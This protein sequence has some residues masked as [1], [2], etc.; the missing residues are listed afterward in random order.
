[1]QN[2]AG[3]RFALFLASRSL[4]VLI[5]E[6]MILLVKN[7]DEIVNLTLLSEMKFKLMLGETFAVLS[8]AVFY[9]GLFYAAKSANEAGYFDNLK[10]IIV[11]FLQ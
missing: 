1:M 11:H 3:N 2:K 9:G 4:I 6:S 7:E 5:Q 8:I 10:K